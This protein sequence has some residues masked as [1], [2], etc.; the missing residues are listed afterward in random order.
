MRIAQTGS[1][2]Q[3]RLKSK[4]FVWNFEIFNKAKSAYMYRAYR[5]DRV[6]FSKTT[7]GRG[8]HHTGV[9]IVELEGK[10]LF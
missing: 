9:G 6:Q 2:F 10:F 8:E 7:Q 5:L 4:N 3:T 1:N